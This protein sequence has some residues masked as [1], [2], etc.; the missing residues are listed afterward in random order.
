MRP[1]LTAHSHSAA[2]PAPVPVERLGPGLAFGAKLLHVRLPWAATCFA[3]DG[4]MVALA[5][6]AAELGA[7]GPAAGSLS[8][9]TLVA[10][11]VLS[12]VL[13]QARGLYGQRLRLD[14]L[15]DARTIVVQLTIAAMAVLTFHVVFTGVASVH[16]GGFVRV[17]TF[18]AIY[19]VAGR[20]VL[21]RS[22]AQARRRGDVVSPTLIIGSGGV[23][24]LA[25]RRLLEH[26]ELGLLPV[27]FVDVDAKPQAS[28]DETFPIPVL[29]GTQELE[30]LADQF[31]VTQVVV[32]CSAIADEPSML[33]VLDRCRERGIAI[34]LVPSLHEKVTGNVRVEHIGSLP[35]VTAYATDPKG[36]QFAVKYL[37]DP[38]VAAVALLLVS[39]VFLAAAAAVYLSLGRPIFYRQTRIGR[40]GKEFEIL[41]FRSMKNAPVGSSSFVPGDGSA[42]GGVE[43][44]DRR[45]RVGTILRKTSIDELPQLLNVLRGDMSLV[46]PRPERPEYVST[47]TQSVYRYGDRHRVKSGITGWAQVHGLRGK[48]CI[49]D[50]AEWDNFY[51]ENFSLWLD[52]KIVFLTVAAVF[53][54]AKSVE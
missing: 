38:L 18:A 48:T 8:T 46:G 5:V 14:V 42:P 51:I 10:F 54:A 44:E 52:V 23:A 43:G 1:A 41:K 24:Q 39:P 4:I 49:A 37:I 20:I 25:A 30:H 15:D 28:R 22:Q 53:T 45:T 50:R 6:L 21:Y 2:N 26:R 29:G 11:A 36:W 35:L 47:F 19:V 13:F 40:D 33:R 3:L 9:G 12:V 32:V 27:G 34:A 16:P 31:D 7:R 17:W